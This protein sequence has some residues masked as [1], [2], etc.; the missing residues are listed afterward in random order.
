[1]AEIVGYNPVSPVEVVVGENVVL[2]L[3]FRNKGNTVWRFIAG[4][5]IWDANGNIIAD[6]STPLSSSLQP[7]QQTTVTWSHR[8]SQAGDFWVQF[9]VW[10]DSPY[11]TQNLM[12]KKPS[13]A[14]RLVVGK[15]IA[16]ARLLSNTLI[17]R[18]KWD[19]RMSLSGFAPNSLI[20]VSSNYSEVECTTGR[21]ITSSWTQVYSTR[22][23]QN[24]NLVIAYLHQG[25]G[26]YTYTFTDER[27]NRASVSFVTSP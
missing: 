20:T 7:G 15:S 8:V 5:T 4:A 2:N 18:C 13:P 26:N 25:T 24:G 12:D 9:G 3:T 23:D 19:V 21:R 6:Y 1:L 17:E 27:G 11:I 14:Q 22:T 16:S 10:K